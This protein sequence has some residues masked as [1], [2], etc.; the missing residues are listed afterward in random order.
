MVCPVS[1]VARGGEGG[2]DTRTQEVRGNGQWACTAGPH[3]EDVL[4]WL[5]TTRGAPLPPDQSDPGCRCD[6]LPFKLHVRSLIVDMDA[7]YD[8]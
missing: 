2:G 3:T 8:G 7:F 1:R 5:T 6:T 4:E